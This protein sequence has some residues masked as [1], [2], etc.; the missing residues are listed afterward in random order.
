MEPD[1]KT[2][3][4]FTPSEV[5]SKYAAM[6]EA[7]HAEMMGTALTNEP[8]INIEPGEIKFPYKET[9][10][11]EIT[12]QLVIDYYSALHLAGNKL[13][14][15]WNG[16][17]DSGSV[18]LNL[19]GKQLE[20]GW[21]DDTELLLYNRIHAWVINK[22][23]NDLDYG[24]WAGEYSANGTADFVIQEGFIGFAGIDYYTEEEGYLEKLD[25]PYTAHIPSEYVPKN[26]DRIIVDVTGGY[27]GDDPNVQI[28]F[29]E[30]GL[31]LSKNEELPENVL[32]F[33]ADLEKKMSTY[34]G[35]LLEKYSGSNVY[36][37]E[38]FYITDRTKEVELL[39]TD[40]NFYK[41]NEVETRKVINLINWV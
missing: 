8:S 26:I 6:G 40:F 23:Y 3:Y 33:I 38:T 14:L 11:V 19:N 41:T 34:F 29:K 35:E 10:D 15:E 39:F 24:S 18:W 17:G 13:Q 16:G 32:Q 36:F 21:S 31:Y 37:D 22:M 25:S 28:H 7:V 1:E 27:D 2:T 4:P 5:F 12:A 9:D 30:T 20:I